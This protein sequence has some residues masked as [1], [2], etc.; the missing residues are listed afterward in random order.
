MANNTAGLVTVSRDSSTITYTINEKSLFF[1]DGYKALHAHLNEGFLKC[2]KSNINGRIKLTYDISKLSPLSQ[3]LPEMTD[4]VYLKVIVGILN[5]AIA[6]RD[7]SFLQHENISLES[8]DIFVDPKTLKT[9]LLYLPLNIHPSANAHIV[10]DNEIRE[11]IV[12]LANGHR[13]I[14]GDFTLEI[15]KDLVK[16]NA[17]FQTVVEKILKQDIINEA[18]SKFRRVHLI[19]D[20]EVEGTNPAYKAEAP[21]KENKHIERPRIDFSDKSYDKSFHQVTVSEKKAISKKKDSKS[22]KTIVFFLVYVLVLIIAFFVAFNYYKNSGM[23]PGFILVLVSLIMGALLVPVL[24]F[25][26]ANKKPSVLNETLVEEKVEGIGKTVEGFIPSMVLRSINDPNNIEFFINKK[27]FVIGKDKQQV[28]GFIPF[29]KSVG[30][31]HC[32]IIWDNGFY[33]YDL[34][35]EFGTFV[36]EVNVIPG[37]KFPLKNKDKIKISKHIFEVLLEK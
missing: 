21:Q 19:G 22:V 29:D 23:A 13:N 33:V 12:K 36:N 2:A 3:M 6:L 10:F 34:D 15:C 5:T 8:T 31:T 18:E 24:Y 16:N 37:Q 25:L 27:E 9:Y 14:V 26:K 17:S 35:S 32:E 20:T 7:I 30:D 1:S 28:Q 11:R 4:K